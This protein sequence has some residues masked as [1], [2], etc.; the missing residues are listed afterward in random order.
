M[1]LKLH[2]Q[3]DGYRLPCL[4][5]PEDHFAVIRKTRH[6][7]FRVELEMTIVHS[8]A[9]PYDRQWKNRRQTEN[10][11]NRFAYVQRSVDWICHGLDTMGRR[12]NLGPIRRRGDELLEGFHIS[13]SNARRSP[14]LKCAALT[15][16]QTEQ[17]RQSNP[18]RPHCRRQLPMVLQQATQATIHT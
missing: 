13:V 6:T 4:P 16:E 17:G 9:L 3:V 18:T 11:F 5:K 10:F 14:Q 7:F 15:G 2:R 12:D 1:R 8:H